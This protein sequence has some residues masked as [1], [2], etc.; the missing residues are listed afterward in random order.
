MSFVWQ[1]REMQQLRK[2]TMHQSG[3]SFS[4]QS[5]SSLAKRVLTFL[6]TVRRNGSLCRD[7]QRKHTPRR[8]G[9]ELSLTESRFHVG[10]VVF[11]CVFSPFPWPN[12][13]ATSRGTCVV[14]GTLKGKARRFHW[15]TELCYRIL[16]PRLGHSNTECNVIYNIL[17]VNK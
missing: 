13:C 10:V 17:V 9:R 6:G 7:P 2:H 8:S 12:S 11:R 15:S 4:N 3:N 1:Q 16:P 5:P 14:V